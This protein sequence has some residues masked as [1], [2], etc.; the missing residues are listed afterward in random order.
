VSNGGAKAEDAYE[1]SA[2]WDAERPDTLVI[3]CS[4]GRWRAATQEFVEHHLSAASHA[5]LVMVPGGIEPL[6]LLDLLPKD[7]N[8]LRRRLEGL[9]ETHGTRRIVAIAHE[10]CGWYRHRRVG[11]V[12][13][14]LRERQLT[15]LKRAA[16]RLRPMFPGV[17]VEAW[18]ARLSDA[19]TPRVV[20]ER[21]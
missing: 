10:D 6:T 18:Y 1:A 9:V 2:R 12:A 4:D 5:D 14:D 20:F 7:F 13:V 21:V 11:P 17:L 16:A 8:F 3:C 19:P 15:D